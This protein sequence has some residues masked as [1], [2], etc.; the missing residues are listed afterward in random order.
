MRTALKRI[1]LGFLAG[2]MIAG[3]YG[4]GDRSKDKNT[5]TDDIT[6]TEGE[7]AV[8]GEEETEVT[9]EQVQS[10][11]GLLIDVAKEASAAPLTQEIIQNQMNEYA[12][13]GY[14]RIYFIP[15]PDTYAVTES[16]Q[17]SVL[18]DPSVQTDHMHRSVHA[19]L[20][21]TLAY[22]MACKNAG[23]ESVVLYSPYEC[24]GSITV[25]DDATVQF[26]FGEM[27]SLGGK[28]VFCISE[29]SGLKTHYISSIDYANGSTVKS[30]SVTEIEVLFVAEAVENKT[31]YNTTESLTPC[32]K[33]QVT[34][35]VW[36]S[37]ENINYR[38]AEGVKYTVAKEEREI[39]DSN[40]TSL[41][42][43]QCYVVRFDVS[44]ISANGYFAFSFDNNQGLYTIP[45]S[46]I[47]AYDKNGAV[48]ETT[49]GVFA[50]NPYS[51]EM[52]GKETVPEDY[53][54]GSERTPILTDDEKSLDA[55][56]AFGFE[57]QY[58]GIGSDYGDGWHQGYVYGVAVG[59][60]Q[61]LHGN[62]DESRADVREY[63]LGQVDRFYA[64]GADAVIIS[65]ENH[66]GMAYDYTRY[67]FNSKYVV[68]Y[69]KRY[70]VNILSESFD[71][72]KLMQLRGEYFMKFLK[73]AETLAERRGKEFG[74]ELFASF[75]SPALDDDLNGLCYYKMPKI[76]FDWKEALEL[77]DSVL[78]KDY[79]FGAYDSGVA[80]EIRAYADEKEKQ[81]IVM[82]YQD[83]GA[84]ESFVVDAL[85][86]K[87]N[88]G[89]V[90][91]FTK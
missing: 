90:T 81:V 14:K 67:G 34:P 20:D 73:D 59:S 45:F 10:E 66:G 80:E 61:F 49:A 11:R 74:I 15:I 84:D 35:T 19:T 28:A 23:I 58:G 8:T 42:K 9:V 21:P 51:D 22:L 54:W 7:D 89:I 86:D 69:Q 36:V 5:D 30:G 37:N 65:L 31:G 25:P 29:F 60:K 63:W 53:F 46:M 71:Y 3:A 33:F 2:L 76:L 12:K 50:R 70:G 88:T 1:L 57:F 16:C 64:K 6:L 18:C 24:G 4:C 52:L 55:F 41:G 85:A 38:R 13:M 40:G 87:L 75:A 44:K 83:L 91:D 39:T 79:V 78:I 68:E 32:D 56:K 72:L 27:K 82:G 48:V 26:S 77:C 17:G 47:T 62:L 43:K